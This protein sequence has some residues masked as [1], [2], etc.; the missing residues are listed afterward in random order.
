MYIIYLKNVLD[1]EN[2][3]HTIDDSEQIVNLFLEELIIQ[4]IAEVE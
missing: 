2:S 3:T 4:T 1:N